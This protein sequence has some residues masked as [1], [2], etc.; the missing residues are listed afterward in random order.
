MPEPGTTRTRAP[1]STESKEVVL[2]MNVN[3]A[4]RVELELPPVIIRLAIPQEFF[5][6]SVRSQ[7]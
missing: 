7:T 2:P 5:A 6:A 3:L 4:E 1:S